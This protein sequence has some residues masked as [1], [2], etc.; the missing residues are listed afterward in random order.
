MKPDWNN[1]VP[2]GTRRARFLCRENPWDPERLEATHPPHAGTAAGRALLSAASARVSFRGVLRPHNLRGPAVAGTMCRRCAAAAVRLMLLSG[3]WLGTAFA[4]QAADDV[5]SRFFEQGVAAL[6]AGDPSQACD[7][8][9]ESAAARPASGT[10]HNLGNAAWRTGQPGRAVLAW[11]QALWLDP[12]NENASTSLRY[13]RHTGNLEEPDLRWFEVCSSWLPQQWWPWI[14]AASFWACA[15]LLILP[16]VFRR[17]RRDWFQALAAAGAAV[18]L[19]C[20]PALAGL[21]SRARL[22]FILPKDAA[23]RV[24]PT[25]EAQVLTYLPSGE[26]ARKQE[27]RGNYV[28]IRTRY[29]IGWVRQD[30]LGLIGE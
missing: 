26:P 6:K 10:L 19:L 11:E 13:A 1:R 7:M 3:L 23:L 20:L 24:T 8:F 27:T 18:F 28:L 25:A 21:N 9:E 4:A 17:R 30:E 2:P 16:A 22:G 29:S 14:A 15:S 12:R 5:A